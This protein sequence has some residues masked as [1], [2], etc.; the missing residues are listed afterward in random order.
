MTMNPLY[1]LAVEAVIDSFNCKL[2]FAWVCLVVYEQGA[3]DRQAPAPYLNKIPPLPDTEKGD[4]LGLIGRLNIEVLQFHPGA[5]GFNKLPARGHPIAHQ[6]GED[7]IGLRRI[8]NFYPFHGASFGVH[9]GFP[10]LGRH[11]FP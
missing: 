3:G 7:A 4:R 6:D 2:F 8:F 11:H 9:G 10:Q 1:P 5:V